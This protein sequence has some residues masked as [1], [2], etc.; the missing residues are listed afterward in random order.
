MP[1]T[2]P[3]YEVRID[4]PGVSWKIVHR[5]PDGGTKVYF[6]RLGFGKSNPFN[7]LGNTLSCS[8]PGF[9][10]RKSVHC[11]CKHVRYVAGLL[12]RAELDPATPF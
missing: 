10:Y 5:L 9:R 6:V 3:E 8:C 1:T 7:P 11:S 2:T 12:G 4:C